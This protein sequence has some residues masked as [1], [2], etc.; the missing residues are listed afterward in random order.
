VNQA[1]EII[2]FGLEKGQR[3]LSEYQAKLILKEYGIPVTAEELVEEPTGVGEAAARIGF[4]VV[5]KSCS[6]EISHK[7]EAG[8]IQVNI[9]DL[10]ELEQAAARLAQAG[11]PAGGG[12][13]VQEMVAG[14]REL[15]MGLIRDPQ[16]G[17][18]VMFGLGGIFTEVLED[19]SFRLA[20]LSPADAREMVGEI[21][22]KKILGAIR[23]MEEVDL[24]LLAQSLIALGQIGLDHPQVSQIDVNPLI[25]RA[26]KPVAVDALFVLEEPQ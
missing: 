14:E 13:L 21:R 3:T 19:V 16:F 7:T 24:E 18:A 20:P 9:K 26:G 17:P 11:G 10:P 23:G 2:R 5:L 22:G 12:L 6:P 1:G 8:L 25:V 4:P 15:V